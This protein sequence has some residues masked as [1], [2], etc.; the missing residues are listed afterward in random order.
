MEGGGEDGI[1]VVDEEPQCLDTL[2][3]I[4]DEVACLL[5]HPRPGWTSG[6]SSQM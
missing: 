6:H 3:Q 1:T 2:A 5:R 4:H